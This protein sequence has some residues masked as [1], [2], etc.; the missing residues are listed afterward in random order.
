[1]S[2]KNSVFAASP[3]G[4]EP[5]L[6]ATLCRDWFSASVAGQPSIS[7]ENFSSRNSA[8][9]VSDAI[10]FAFFA[11]ADASRQT[12]LGLTPGSYFAGRSAH[13][14]AFI[15][16][17]VSF[18]AL[19]VFRLIAVMGVDVDVQYHRRFSRM[20]NTARVKK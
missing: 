12:F 1:M 18:P 20:H 4:V 9:A 17:L 7:A 19:V 15:R 13:L 3:F 11:E 2:V 14:E 10:S 5:P 16:D 6:V 8:T